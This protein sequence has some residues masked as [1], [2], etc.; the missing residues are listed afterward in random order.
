MKKMLKKMWDFISEPFIC[1]AVVIDESK[2]INENGSWDKY[3]EKK[4][5]RLK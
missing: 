3:W 2:R 4:N 1:I 5:R